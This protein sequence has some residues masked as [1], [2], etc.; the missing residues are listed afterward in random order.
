MEV[1]DR[2]V[3]MNKGVI[4]QIGAPAEVYENP[5][6][7]FVYHFLGDANRLY[8][9]DDHH[10]LFRRMRFTSRARLKTAIRPEKCAISVRWAPLPA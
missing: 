3:V 6:S 2:I 1:A 4:E 7:D 8:V 5:A 9:G 10:V